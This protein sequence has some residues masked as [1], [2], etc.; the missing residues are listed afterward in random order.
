MTLELTV[1]PLGPWPG[2]KRTERRKDAA[3]KRAVQWDQST[4]YRGPERIPITQTLAELRSELQAIGCTRAVLEAGFREQ[5]IGMSGW[6]LTRARVPQDPGVILRVLESKQGQLNYPCDT[7]TRWEDNLRAIML[8]L[9]AQ[10]KIERYGAAG[11]GEQYAGW[12]ALP[13]QGTATLNADAAARIIIARSNGHADLNLAGRIATELLGSLEMA[14]KSVRAARK[15]THPDAGGSTAAFQDVEH[16][17]G[18][19]AAHFG[20]D[21]L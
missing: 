13:A 15:A 10:R 9:E 21:R 8:T 12:R 17:A 11:R 16:A 5:D 19:L 4:G 6:P 3:F 18:V 7:F 20:E 14:R 2:G 1:R